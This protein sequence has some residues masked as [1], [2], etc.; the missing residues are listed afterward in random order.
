MHLSENSNV[1]SLKE[2]DQT[3]IGQRLTLVNG[4]L[5]NEELKKSIEKSGNKVYALSMSHNTSWN[6]EDFIGLQET[7]F[8]RHEPESKP[9]KSSWPFKCQKLIPCTTLPYQACGC[10]DRDDTENIGMVYHLGTD[11]KM[12]EKLDFQSCEE[13]KTHGV[14]IRGYFSIN[15][16][17]RYCENWSKFLEGGGISVFV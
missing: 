8:V 15:G 5:T 14:S 7:D 13:L 11:S 1:V 2:K 9:L 17:D 4:K 12:V 16:Q 3:Q 6:Q 10:E